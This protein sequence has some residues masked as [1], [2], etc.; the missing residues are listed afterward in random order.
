MQ[1]RRQGAE[2]RGR[3]LI[4]IIDIKKKV[5][6][7]IGDATNAYWHVAE[8]E[9]GACDPPPEMLE[10]RRRK[11]L[12]TDVWLKLEKKP[13]GRRN[14][15]AKYGFLVSVLLT[16]IGCERCPRDPSFLRH[17]KQELIIEIHQ[18]DIHIAGPEASLEWIKDMLEGKILVKW[19]DIIKEGMRYSHLKRHRVLAKDGLWDLGNKK[20]PVEILRTLG[21][22]DCSPLSC[23]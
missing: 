18:D 2:A 16:D 4:N 10:E 1:V 15:S 3:R 20:Y 13:Y 19:S 21:M 9:L 14:A 23:G 5:F 8:D 22:E 17:V 6:F 11:G 7:L 12:R